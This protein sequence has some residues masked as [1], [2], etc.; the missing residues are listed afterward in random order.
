MS[1]SEFGV[2]VIGTATAIVIVLYDSSVYFFVRSERA[3]YSYPKTSTDVTR[4]KYRDLLIVHKWEVEFR[5][6]RT[7]VSL[8]GTRTIVLFTGTL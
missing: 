2:S 4:F 6:L 3:G 5:H 7:R 1:V 8:V